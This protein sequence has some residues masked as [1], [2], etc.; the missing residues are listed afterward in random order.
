MNK[1]LGILLAGLATVWMATP[2]T[3]AGTPSTQSALGVGVRTHALSS[4]FEDYP[5]D[6][7]D[8]SYGIAY[9]YHESAA[10]WQLGVDFADNANRTNTIDTVITPQLNLIFKDNIWR[11]GAGILGSYITYSSEDPEAEDEWTDLYYQFL[12]GISIPVGSIAI[13]VFAAYPFADWGD[14]GDFEAGDI[15]VQGWVKYLF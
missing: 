7:G 6:D 12:L 10:Y 2:A 13:D 14:L 1:Y 11:G 9:E 8:L 3:H 4:T 15:E 5:Y